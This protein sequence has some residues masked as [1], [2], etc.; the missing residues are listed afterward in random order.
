MRSPAARDAAWPSCA[1]RR[2][3]MA[4]LFCADARATC[5]GAPKPPL[6]LG[7]SEARSGPRCAPRLTHRCAVF[8]QINDLALPRYGSA[9]LRVGDVVSFGG[10][11][12]VR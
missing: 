10:A 3:C 9:V 7:P 6:E 2:V 11:A 8:L 12:T 5:R 4:R 1:A